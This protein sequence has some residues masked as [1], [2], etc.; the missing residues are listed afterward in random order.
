VAGTGCAQYYADTE[1]FLIPAP[2][3]TDLDMAVAEPLTVAIDAVEEAE[4]P[5]GGRVVV[6]GA[7]PIGLMVA[8]VAKSRGALKVIVADLSE[9]VAKLKLA[10]KWNIDE[11][12]EVDKTSLVDKILELIPEGA[13]SVIVTAPPPVLPQAIRICTYGGK[14]AVLG[15]DHRGKQ[16]VEID[17]N[18]FHFQNI[19]IKG[20]CNCPIFRFPVAF[21]ML[22]SKFIDSAELVSH[23]FPLPETGKAFDTAMNKRR[24]VIKVAVICNQE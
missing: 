8:K 14:I 2:G 24:E 11:V 21:D 19:A 10:K 4:V 16:V 20:A 9:S 17:V 6:I 13:D 23:T 18:K 12:I 22:R 7:G 5:V 3:L 15:T 1:E